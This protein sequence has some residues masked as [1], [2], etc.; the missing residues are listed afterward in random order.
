[1]RFLETSID[2]IL[3]ISILSIADEAIG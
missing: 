1:M 3:I 2:S